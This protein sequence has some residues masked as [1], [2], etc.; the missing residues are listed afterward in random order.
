MFFPCLCLLEHFAFL[1]SKILLNKFNISRTIHINVFIYSVVPVYETVQA[2]L[3]EVGIIKNYLL[4]KP[5]ATAL[6]SA[7]EKHPTAP[8]CSRLV[9]RTP[10]QTVGN[11]ALM[12]GQCL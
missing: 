4:I 6:E 8:Q 5:I 9:L 1:C 2:S 10:N 3:K 11:S 7:S 12:V